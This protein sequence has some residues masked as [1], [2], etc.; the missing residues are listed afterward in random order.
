MLLQIAFLTGRVLSLVS[1]VSHS[2]IALLSLT[3]QCSPSV[4]YG[5]S[6]CR[7]QFWDTITHLPCR[8]C[9]TPYHVALHLHHTQCK[10]STPYQTKPPATY[11]PV[12][13]NGSLSWVVF[14]RLLHQPTAENNKFQ[15][16]SP[17]LIKES[18]IWYGGNLYLFLLVYKQIRF[19]VNL[20]L[21]KIVLY[22][23]T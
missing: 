6:G 21:P 14:E 16:Q 3:I 17:L 7:G 10:C 9:S 1:M 22:A 8:K 12:N 13:V 11:R 20:Q 2:R 4:V 18:L 19:Y 15:S 5:V 23:N